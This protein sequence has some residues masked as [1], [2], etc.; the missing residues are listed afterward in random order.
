[1]VLGTL[2][3]ALASLGVAAP[4]AADPP[5]TRVD[6]EDWQQR[7]EGANP[8][9]SPGGSPPPFRAQEDL[10]DLRREEEKEGLRWHPLEPSGHDLSLWYYP[11]APCPLWGY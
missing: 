7:P 3:G 8:V 1:M 6:C 11:G 10:S 2:G 9:G 5:Q 4:T